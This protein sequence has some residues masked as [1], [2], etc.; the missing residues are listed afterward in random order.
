ME[1]N[2][3]GLVHLKPDEHLQSSYQ[4]AGAAY[5]NPEKASFINSVEFFKGKLRPV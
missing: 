5:H 1:E 2:R 3:L 4:K